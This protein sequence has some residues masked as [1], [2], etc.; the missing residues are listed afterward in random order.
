[1]KKTGAILFIAIFLLMALAP[2]AGMMIFGPAEPAAKE[3]LALPPSLT[4]GEG[5]F[6]QTVLNDA[7]DYLSDRF[8]LRQELITANAVLEAAV[9][10]ESA[11]PK[12]VLGREGWLFYAETLDSYQ[13]QNQLSARQ[14]W[15]AAHSLRLIRDYALSQ[16]AET[17]FIPV[18]NKNSVYGEY[19]PKSADK[20]QDQSDYDRLLDACGAE[21]VAVV[22]LL[23]P[24]LDKK[25]E[26]QLYQ[27]LDSHW[28]NLGAALANDL[29]LDAIQ[30][31]AVKTG[32]EK[33]GQIGGAERAFDPTGFQA[34]RDHVP[35]LYTMLYPAGTERDLQYE[36]L[37]EP[38][39][40]YVRPIRTTED[41]RI[42]TSC[43][44]GNGAL[45]M[46]RDSFGNT[47][48][49]FLAEDFAEAC[50]SRLMPYDLRLFE[51]AHP[52]VL[53]LEITERH[54]SWLAKRPPILPAPIQNLEQSVARTGETIPVTAEED[55]TG[56]FRVSGELA[57]NPDTCSPVWIE[58][59]GTVYEASPVGETERSFTAYLPQPAR[60]IRVLCLTGGELCASPTELVTP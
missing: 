15:A 5:K 30:Q 4:D 25:K 53:L 16:G 54:L 55:E 14:L 26:V 35:D 60:T 51:A 45:L 20:T 21:G 10:N 8:W 32:A 39:F 48:H 6:N 46:F 13:G 41:L 33:L 49:S 38:R 34:V 22:D 18:P 2:A 36:A 57:M 17:W 7:S 44:T 19:M 1:M 27:R 50:F 29:I 56:F 42:N 9:F 24:F 58:A 3:Y 28:N 37:R 23:E 52:D 12:V 40:S 47:L 31:S 43:E 59:D 11:S